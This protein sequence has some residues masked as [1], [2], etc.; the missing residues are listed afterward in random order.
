V[1]YSLPQLEALMKRAV[2]EEPAGHDPQV[3]GELCAGLAVS[4][5]GSIGVDTDSDQAQ[6]I[7]PALV[8]IAICAFD[9]GVFAE[10]ELVAER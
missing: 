6:L 3:R 5:L 4:A 10:R 9:L 2:T 1:S 7:G 8:T